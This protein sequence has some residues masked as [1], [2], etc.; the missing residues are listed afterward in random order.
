VA[1]S[2]YDSS[3]LTRAQHG[4]QF[5]AALDGD[6]GA[7]PAWAGAHVAGE[8]RGNIGLT[9][10]GFDGPTARGSPCSEESALTFGN[11]S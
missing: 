10:V 11:L 4:R 7:L 5:L 9:F 1:G 8:R 2:K 3:P 6:R